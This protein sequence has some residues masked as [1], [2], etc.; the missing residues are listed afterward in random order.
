[1]SELNTD[2]IVLFAHGSRAPDLKLELGRVAELVRESTGVSIVEM[3]FLEL[4]EPDMHYGVKSC[5]EQGAKR[6]TVVPYLL[7]VGNHLRR[8]LP[9][10]IA[11]VR[12]ENPDIEILMAPHLG[13]DQ[14][15]ADLVAKRATQAKAGEDPI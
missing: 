8:D 11:E 10:L 6:V 3:A 1:M 13:A 12:K 14:L 7:N 5:M 4:T 2:A 9:S 15:L